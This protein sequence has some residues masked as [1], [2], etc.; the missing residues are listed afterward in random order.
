MPLPITAQ[1]HDGRPPSRARP[2]SASSTQRVGLPPRRRMSAPDPTTPAVTLWRGTATPCGRAFGRDGEQSDRRGGQLMPEVIDW[3]AG[4]RTVGAPLARSDP[5]RDVRSGKCQGPRT[6]RPSAGATPSGPPAN[7]CTAARLPSPFPPVS[8]GR[9]VRR[10]MPTLMALCL[11]AS[12]VVDDRSAGALQSMAS[13]RAGRFSAGEACGCGSLAG[14]RAAS[15]DTR[16][17]G[18]RKA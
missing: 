8:G 12:A 14:A 7:H 2:K 1:P 6:V 3:R 17:D 4:I 10:P 16:A 15:S 11:G 9:R 13:W 18:R 5:H